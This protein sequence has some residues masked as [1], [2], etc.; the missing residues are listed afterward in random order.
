[1]NDGT[2]EIMISHA[3][4]ELIL[5]KTD[6]TLA[7]TDGQRSGSL[8]ILDRAMSRGDCS[9]SYH[10]SEP[11]VLAKRPTSGHSQ[12]GMEGSNGREGCRAARGCW[13]SFRFDAY[14]GIMNSVPEELSFDAITRVLN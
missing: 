1:M 12:P 14:A 3:W 6:V 13:V 9:D 10:L 7:I 8:L 5:K 4:V 2:D 11:P